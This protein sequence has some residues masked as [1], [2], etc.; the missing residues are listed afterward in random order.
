MS[1]TAVTGIGALICAAALAAAAPAD[2]S[3][4]NGIRFGG[5]EGR[6]HP[7]FELESR[8]DSNVLYAASGAAQGDLVLHFR[9]G[10]SLDVP[11]DLAQVEFDGKLDWAQYLGLEGSTTDLSRLYGNA[12]LGVTVNRN[13][14]VGLILDDAFTRSDR[15]QAVSIPSSAVANYNQ[16]SLKL[17]FRPGGGALLFG[18]GGEWVLESYEPFFGGAS[19]NASFCLSDLGYNEVR[20]N[21]EA[22]WKFL[23]RT[24]AVLEAM[25]FDRIPNNTAVSTQVDGIRVKTGVTGLVTPHFAATLKLGYGD[26]L[27]SADRTFRTFLADV[28][29]EWIGS[30]YLGASAGYSHDFGSDPFK[31]FALYT[32]NRMW[33]E[34]HL[35]LATRYAFKMLLGWDHLGYELAPGTTQYVRVNPTIEAAVA[36]WATVTVGYQLSYRHSTVPGT[37][38]EV[39]WNYTKNEL[40]LG[41]RFT[42]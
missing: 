42:Y 19:C 21:G 7:Y 4:G 12:S 5:S 30:E 40:W 23:P 29:G 31:A 26:A 27:G 28:S 16:L 39:G 18:L 3:P 11:G 34:G 24:Q 35:V 38:T 37:A 13:G 8:Y 10:V 36:R 6:L 1:R 20:V 25:F 14:T 32:V 2:A 22:R 15:P 17:P 9:P 33:G 41:A